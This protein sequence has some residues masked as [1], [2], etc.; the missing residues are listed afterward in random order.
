MPRE[1]LGIIEQLEDAMASA[2]HGL[3]I[4][5]GLRNDPNSDQALRWARR[6]RELI[7]QGN[8]AEIA[9]DVVAK[10]LFLDYKT[11]V[12]ASEADTLEALLRAAEGK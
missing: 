2:G 1:A 7:R 12:Y 5:Y 11:H 3:R 10:E 8:S 9:G 6:V 4:K